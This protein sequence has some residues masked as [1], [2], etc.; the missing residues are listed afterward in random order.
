MKKSLVAVGVVAALGVLWTAGAWFTGK[1]MESRFAD[2]VQQANTQLK[3]T[4]PEA[5]VE[6]SYQDYQ[7]GLF[8]SSL[9]L[10][11]QPIAGKQSP[12]LESGQRIIFDEHVAHGP[13]PLG[14]SFSLIPAMASVSSELVNNEVTKPLFDFAQG[15]PPFSARTRVG[16]SG[17]TDT[18]VTL[19][20]MSYDANNEK[21]AFS[22]GQVQLSSERGGELLTLSAEAKSAVIEVINEY[23]QRVRFSFSNLNTRGSSE[24]TPFAERIGSQKISVDKLAVA[25]EGN[26]MLS[27]EGMNLDGASTL[28]DDKK[29]INTVLDYTLNSLKLQNKDIGSGKLALKINNLDGEA[30]HQFSRGY[31]AL[32]TQVA[33]QP[34]MADNPELYRQKLGEALILSLPLLLKGQPEFSI[35]P[36]SW[37]NAKG[38]TTFNLALKLNNRAAATSEPKTLGED[39]DRTIKSLDSTLSVSAPM[40]REFMTQVALLEGF[41]P[42]MASKIAAQKVDSLAGMAERFQ[43]ARTEGDNIIS[44]LQYANSEVTFNGKKMPPEALFMMFAELERLQ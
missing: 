14:K 12:L 9:Q 7:R 19:Q 26:D 22:G 6:F 24:M 38:E 15:K 28:S 36:L 40:A 5:A 23:N 43:L 27:L 35:A 2:L 34:G 32:V 41:Q 25:I 29:S 44:R 33:T 30:W 11:L 1:Q 4:A 16:Y 18:D 21:V 13:F 42:E 31:D 20:P 37:K 3:K 17:A 10:V 39:L 8:S